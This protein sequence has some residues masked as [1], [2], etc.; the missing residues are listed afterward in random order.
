MTKVSI[1]AEIGS[2]HDGSFGNA[3][4]LIEAA[5]RAGADV[6]KFQTHIAEAETLPNAPMPAYFKGEPRMDYF[7]RTGFSLPQ[8]RELNARRRVP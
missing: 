3:T 6:I 2:V 5:A 8:W 7:R 4:K 1:I